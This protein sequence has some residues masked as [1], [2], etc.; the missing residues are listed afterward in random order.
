MAAARWIVQPRTARHRRA[1]RP[2]DARRRSRSLPAAAIRS[3]VGVQRRPAAAAGDVRRRPARDRLDIT[4]QT[5]T[6]DARAP[7]RWGSPVAPSA[8]VGVPASPAVRRLRRGGVGRLDHRAA[9]LPR[10]R[11]R[12]RVPDDARRP[13]ERHQ[14]RAGTEPA[15][16][17]ERASRAGAVLRP[18]RAQRHLAA[19]RRR[20]RQS[21]AAELPRHG[22]RG[23]RLPVTRTACH[24]SHDRDRS[25][26]ERSLTE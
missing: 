2:A 6:L 13:P 7:R 23:V 14:P 11:V 8:A 17:G 24:Q 5:E 3:G 10:V 21:S 9:R 18:D 12:G 26:S 20:R 16:L 15:A 22:G 25:S 1:A 19:L 4:T